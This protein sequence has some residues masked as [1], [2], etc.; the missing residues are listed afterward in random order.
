[1]TTSSQRGLMPV[2]RKP[3][4]VVKRFVLNAYDRS[5]PLRA[6]I[7]KYREQVS[8]KY[9]GGYWLSKSL[10]K[11]FKIGFAVLV[12][13]RPEHLQVC[14]DSLFATNIYD[15]DITFL[16]IDDGSLNPRV[17]EIIECPRDAKYKIVRKFT[18]KGP[19]SWGGAFNKAIKALQEI[20][21]FDI[22]GTSDSDAFFHPDWL[23][24]TMEICIW[25]KKNHRTHNLGPFSCFNSSDYKFH[26]ILG[27]YESP[28]GAYLV[29]ERMGA[30]NYFYFSE[31]FEKLGFF[32]ENKDD[33]TLMTEKFK[34]LG[35]R[36][37]ST[38]T[39]YV[40]HLGEDS[41]LDQWRPT[42]VTGITAFAM[43]PVRQGWQIPAASGVYIPKER[44][45]NNLVIQVRYGGLGDH[46]FYSHI[47]RIAKEF[48][49]YDGVYISERSDFR[50]AETRELVW[51][52]NPYVDGFCPSQGVS[53][54]V[55]ELKR[56]E[57]FL[58]AVMRWYGLDDGIRM[59][60]P[61][62][63]YKPKQIDRLVDR[64]LYDPN[65]ISNAGHLESEDIERFFKERKVNVD[66][67]MAVRDISL[68]VPV[69]EE[70]IRAQN[71]MEFCDIISSVKKVYCLTTGTAT[72][73]SALGCS[74]TVIYGDGINKWFHHSPMHQYINIQHKKS[75]RKVS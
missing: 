75:F 72:L 25:A 13:E 68:P 52:L 57:N 41:I 63:Y 30:L 19:N 74:A 64:V 58:D 15:Y 10:P 20:D 44:L 21:T 47:P 38:E 45:G 28:Y 5:Q 69:F 34:S 43:H 67:Q 6:M 8:C 1:M 61:E 39:S 49:G 18:P 17:R 26:N 59:H 48:G 65:Y 7:N 32:P 54:D 46:L 23:K 3:L 33:E 29:K 16:L 53:A 62:I 51:S 36:N 24:A 31:D 35:V 55:E 42:P 2:I 71:L 60:E 40:E 73:C 14:L 11:K 70:E 12:H 50:S 37:F 9:F 66:C 56:G 4:G 22:I 27:R